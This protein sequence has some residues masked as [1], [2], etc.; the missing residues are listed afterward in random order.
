MEEN[1]APGLRNPGWPRAGSSGEQGELR[2]GWR[3][4]ATEA[5]RKA[6][7]QADVNQQRAHNNDRFI[8]REEDDDSGNQKPD[9]VGWAT[10]TLLW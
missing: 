2:A 5:Q 10:P 4:L 9:E 7:R 6:Q 8:N 3:P 1:L